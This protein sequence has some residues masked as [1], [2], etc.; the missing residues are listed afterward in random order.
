MRPTRV[1]P[2]ED[3][4]IKG[5]PVSDVAKR[6]CAMPGIPREHERGFLASRAARA[7]RMRLS[8]KTITDTASAIPAITTLTTST[9]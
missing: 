9:L 3:D 8:M 2:L 1:D 6:P 7:S 4:N 5:G